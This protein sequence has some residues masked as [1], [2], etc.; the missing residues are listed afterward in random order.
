MASRSID[1][2][3]PSPTAT[4]LD[5]TA[6][7]TDMPMVSSIAANTFWPSTVSRPSDQR[8]V[9]VWMAVDRRLPNAPKMLPRR[10]MAAG[11]STSS[12]G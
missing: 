6:S 1:P 3:S 8:K 9:P 10:P 7:A 5:S 12:P 11:T 4:P 2:V